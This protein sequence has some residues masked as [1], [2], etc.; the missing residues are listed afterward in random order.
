[1]LIAPK[2]LENIIYTSVLNS[3]G[4]YNSNS[5]LESINNYV[6]SIDDVALKMVFDTSG[7]L[8]VGINVDNVGL[9]KD[10]TLAKIA[11]A[12]GSVGT[13]D[14]LSVI[15]G[16]NVG[17]AKDSTVIK[18]TNALGSV[19][20]DNFLSIINGDNVGLAKDATLSKMLP[21][22]LAEKLFSYSNT[23]TATVWEPVFAS[24]VSIPEDGEYG[25]V[26]LTSGVVYAKVKLTIGTNPPYEGALNDGNQLTAG[27]LNVFYGMFSEGD[28]VN[29][30][31]GIPAG[32]SA[33]GV[34]RIFKR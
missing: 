20:T 19:G 15:N 30:E 26:I 6:K 29:I 25:I 9:A 16:D 12:L 24:D 14:I 1:M 34:V 17:L 5:L 2:T 23:G 3:L 33:D 11:N 18:I 7:N 4:E 8:L 22:K 28:L 10:A 13:D 32:G 31:L 21:E 27:T